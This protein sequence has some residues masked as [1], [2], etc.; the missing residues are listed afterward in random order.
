MK[1]F[2]QGEK[3]E[4]TIQLAVKDAA[5]VI[6]PFDLT[7]N[8]EISACFELGSTRIQK[9]RVASP[10]GVVVVGVATDGKIKATLTATETDTFAKG[11]SGLL[12]IT[13]DKGSGNI[14]KFQIKNAFQVEKKC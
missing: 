11:S 3:V 7:S 13:V 10:V 8:T 4:L 9:N 5:G 2:I 14:T 12:E 1:K 6:R